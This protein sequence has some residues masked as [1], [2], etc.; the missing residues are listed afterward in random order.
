MKKNDVEELHTLKKDR[1]F[2]VKVQS[3]MGNSEQKSSID[4]IG[5]ES[6]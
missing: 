5:Q 6:L 1:I 2:C 3:E 4:S